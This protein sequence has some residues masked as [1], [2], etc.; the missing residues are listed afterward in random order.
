MNSSA[1]S[2]SDCKTL[3]L[4]AKNAL[5]K[6]C[7]LSVIY[8]SRIYNASPFPWM[9]SPS[10]NISTNIWGKIEKHMACSTS[11]ANCFSS[12]HAFSFTFPAKA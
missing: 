10:S 12:K 4:E 7:M 8:H 3:N 1:S 2:I 9:T 6:C 5:G 11:L